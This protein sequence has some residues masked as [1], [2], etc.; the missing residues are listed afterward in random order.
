MKARDPNVSAKATVLIVTG[1]MLIAFLVALAVGGDPFEHSKWIWLFPSMLL[2]LPLLLR[3]AERDRIRKSIEAEGGRVL[4]LKR[5]SLWLQ[6]RGWIK[7]WGWRLWQGP[8]YEVEF[9]DGNGMEHRRFCRSSL[10]Y[11]VQWASPPHS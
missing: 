6:F 11:G 9:L 8:F 2:G 1:A 10:Y 4:R 7:D 3:V 5:L